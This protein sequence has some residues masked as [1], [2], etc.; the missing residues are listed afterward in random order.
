MTSKEKEQFIRQRAS[1]HI[2]ALN[3]KIFWSLHAVK[4]LRIESLRKAEVENSLKGCIIV[5]DYPLESRPLPDCLVLGFAGSAPVHV[6]VA[7]DRDFDRILIVTV[8]RPSAERW[9][10]DWKKRKRQN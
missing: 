9:E 10:D 5:E 6:V 2:P 8:Y 7:I 3:E 1:E 4:K